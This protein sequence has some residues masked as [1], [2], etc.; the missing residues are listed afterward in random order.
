MEVWRDRAWASLDASPVRCRPF[1]CTSGEHLSGRRGLGFITG[2][3]N[4]R[5]MA[6]NGLEL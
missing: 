3:E 2:P 6:G 4:P 1:D 5:L